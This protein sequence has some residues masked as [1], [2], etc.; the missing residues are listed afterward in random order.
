MSAGAAEV[1]RPLSAA[2]PCPGL[3]G[4]PGRSVSYEAPSRTFLSSSPERRQ[5]DH[6]CRQGSARGMRGREP[7]PSDAR[8]GRQVVRLIA[9]PGPQRPLTT[10]PNDDWVVSTE[11]GV[12]PMSRAVGELVNVTY[13]TL[14]RPCDT[15]SRSAGRLV[16]WPQEAP[17][18]SGA[19]AVA[20]RRRARCSRSG[21]WP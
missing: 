11:T 10:F 14:Q 19:T 13:Q 6:D 17:M 15:R 12:P 5:L 1:H 2:C 3:S 9:T 20:R 21:S 4:D 8:G 7:I 18:G 16:A